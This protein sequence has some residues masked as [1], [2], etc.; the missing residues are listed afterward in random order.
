MKRRV[1]VASL[2]A[3]AAMP[4]TGTAQGAA[5]VIRV[6]WLTAQQASSL[7]PYVDAMRT[8]LADLGYV[9]GRNLVT[10]FRYGDDVIER[11]RT[12]RGA[13]A[14]AGR[15]YRGAR[16]SRFRDSWSRP[17]RSRRIQHE[18]RSRV[19]SVR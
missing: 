5:R 15:S 11:T 19:G 12:R 3:M 4:R 2:V 6:G 17:A 9:E 16:R 8:A 7:V 14:T 13:G 1:F 10:E 18:R